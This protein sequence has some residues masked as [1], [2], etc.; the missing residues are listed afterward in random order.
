MGT[1]FTVDEFED[2]CDSLYRLVIVASRRAKQISKAESHGF[3]SVTSAKKSTVTA[4]EEILEDKVGFYIGGDD[5]ND[6]LE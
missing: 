1:P 5:D 6:L 4:L 3:G 2:K